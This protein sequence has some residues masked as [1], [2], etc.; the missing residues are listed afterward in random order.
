VRN[1]YTT[2]SFIKKSLLIHGD[3]YLY[4]KVK[5]INI[6][7]KIIIVCKIHGEFVQTPDKHLRHGCP[8][9]GKLQ[10]KATNILNH[11]NNLIDKFNKIHNNLYDYSSF[12]YSG[13]KKEAII[14]CKIHGEFKQ[15]AHK[16]LI[17]HG[18]SK[19]KGG[20][21]YSLETFIEKAIK[22][23]NN[24]YNYDFVNYINSKTKVKIVCSKHGP[25]EQ[26]PNNH[27]YGKG[28]K[29]CKKSKGEV[30]ITEILNIS[31]IL[32]EEQK[33]FIDCKY[34]NELVFDFYLPKYNI[35]IE[36]DGEQ[37]FKKFRFEND[38]TDLQLRILRDKIKEQYC[39]LK[40]IKL[41]RFNYKQNKREIKQIIK[42]MTTNKTFSMIK[43]DAVK[44]GHTGAILKLIEDHGFKIV[45]LKMLNLTK[46]DACKFYE[47]HKERPFFNDLTTYMS[48]GTIVAFVLEK[49]NAVSDYRKLIGATNPAMAE[50]GTI[51]KLF[52]KSIE[53][54]A[55]HGSDSD[56]NAIIESTF[57]FK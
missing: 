16:H 21:K 3:K 8:N 7:E 36:Y 32:F 52:A 1:K 25:F 39:L 43:P 27:L 10:S 54:N 50:E 2:E 15:T 28:C 17:G 29:K 13:I 33:R 23:H 44:D 38:E 48:S 24:K 6:K 57:F 55:V 41:F 56:E 4:N 22:K 12:K 30:L 46:E 45:E 26:T 53:A 51:R 19:C 5:Y 40:N 9:C 31:N 49:E 34:V 35:C 18:C 37:H 42:T 20:V 11:F 47:V 14:I